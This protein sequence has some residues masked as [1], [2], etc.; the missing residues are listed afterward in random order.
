MQTKRNLV[1]GELIGLNARVVNSAGKELIG[2]TGKIVDETQNTIAIETNG[3]EKIIPK[4]GTKIE[5]TKNGEKITVDG[6]IIA[7]RP[8]DRTKKLW[9]LK[10]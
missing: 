7:L 2:L 5:F 1:T 6:E 3:M 9:N 10:E 4:K 8:E